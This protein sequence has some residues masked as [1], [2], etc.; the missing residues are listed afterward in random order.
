MPDTT[1]SP[2]APPAPEVAPVT[3][4]VTVS[5][6]APPP[7]P[8]PPTEEVPPTAVLD[9]DTERAFR[10]LIDG[11]N[12]V[13]SQMEGETVAGPL[14]LDADQF[15]VLVLALA[16]VVCLLAFVAIVMLRR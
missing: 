12:A 7:L 13:S 1:T 2:G 10:E 16:L 4:T 6:V 14:V 11:M 3:E 15:G 9:E 8:P 5:E